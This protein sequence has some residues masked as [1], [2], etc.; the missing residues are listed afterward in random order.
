MNPLSKPHAQSLHR[1]SPLLISFL[2][3]EIRLGTIIYGGIW[4]ISH[5]MSER[6]RVE[7]EKS[8]LILEL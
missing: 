3:G 7:Q 1:K 4:V 2:F 6:K 8:A 5:D